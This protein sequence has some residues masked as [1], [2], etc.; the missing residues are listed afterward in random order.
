MVIFGDMSVNRTL[1][2]DHLGCLSRS[3]FYL[4]VCLFACPSVGHPEAVTRGDTGHRWRWWQT[5]QVYTYSPTPEVV[6]SH[7]CQNKTNNNSSRHLIDNVWQGSSVGVQKEGGGKSLMNIQ[8]VIF[9]AKTNLTFWLENK[10]SDL[11]FQAVYL[12]DPPQSGLE[13]ATSQKI[14]VTVLYHKK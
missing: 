5:L 4:L 6:Y 7:F 1:A 11:F 9:R 8:T 13:G 12:L 3:M 10:G 2:A 14:N